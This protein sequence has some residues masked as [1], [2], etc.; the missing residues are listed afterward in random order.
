M[1]SLTTSVS[2]FMFGSDTVS[3]SFFKSNDELKSAQE[4]VYHTWL[5]LSLPLW[6]PYFVSTASGLAFWSLTQGLKKSLSLDTPL[7]EALPDTLQEPV[8]IALVAEPE[9]EPKSET[10]SEIKVEAALVTAPE[11]EPAPLGLENE[12]PVF[13]VPVVE[14]PVVEAPKMVETKPVTPAKLPPRRKPTKY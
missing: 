4:K 1:L 9:I 3:N 11:P 7:A 6:M 10:V 2:E 14:M 12:A 5:G 13:E 8:A